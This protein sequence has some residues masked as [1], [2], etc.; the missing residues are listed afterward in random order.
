M[1]KEELQNAI[2]LRRQFIESAFDGMFSS[3]NA[4][5]AKMAKDVCGLSVDEL[6]TVFR[7]CSDSELAVILKDERPRFSKKRSPAK[8]RNLN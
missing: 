1:S 8:S 2:L 4:K 3:F 6:E 5:Q 7:D